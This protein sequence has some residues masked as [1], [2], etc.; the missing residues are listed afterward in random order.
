M[1]LGIV[2]QSVSSYHVCCVAVFFSWHVCNLY[3]LIIRLCLDYFQLNVAIDKA[4]SYHFQVAVFIL[5]YGIFLRI[6]NYLCNN[7]SNISLTLMPFQPISQ[8]VSLGPINIKTAYNIVL[9]E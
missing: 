9:Q 5:I 2:V 4:S 7:L 3:L 1:I 8:S 6:I